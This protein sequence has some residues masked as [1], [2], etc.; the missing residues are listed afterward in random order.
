MTKR[1]FILIVFMSI[2]LTYTSLL[3][4]RHTMVVHLG[5]LDCETPC[6]VVAAG[7]PLPFLVDG[8]I[9]PIGSVSMDPLVLLTGIDDINVLAL[10]IS[11]IFWLILSYLGICCW[12]TLQNLKK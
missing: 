10:L 4:P 6:R 8:V 1:R 12:Y 2:I 11:W 5:S 9:S 7:F 3:V